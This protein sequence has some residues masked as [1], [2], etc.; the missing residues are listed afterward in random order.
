MNHPYIG[1][2]AKTRVPV[3]RMGLDR[4]F[5]EGII[6]YFGMDHIEYGTGPGLYASVVLLLEEGEHKGEHIGVALEN[7]VILNMKDLI[8]K[9]TGD[10]TDNEKE[11]VRVGLSVPTHKE[12]PDG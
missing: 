7:I 6:V 11:L 1:Q 9:L 5:Y 2:R 12:T 8:P 3:S 10:L 4:G